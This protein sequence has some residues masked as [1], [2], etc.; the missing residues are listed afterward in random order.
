M[1][2]F[3]FASNSA[4]LMSCASSSSVSSSILSR[5]VGALG[6]LV[7]ALVVA[8]VGAFGSLGAPSAFVAG[9]CRTALDGR[10]GASS[11]TDGSKPS[12]RKQVS[13]RLDERTEA[14]GR[15]GFEGDDD[16]D[17]DG[18]R[19][20]RRGRGG[21]GGDGG[22]TGFDAGDDGG[23]LTTEMEIE[24]ESDRNLEQDLSATGGFQ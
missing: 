11:P 9:R 17:D 1:I 21:S 19:G 10:W 20:A 12:L 6:S 2:A 22:E 16:D 14:D 8:L 15:G 4:R 23:L 3:R 18:P 7:I 5:V 13:D 24:D